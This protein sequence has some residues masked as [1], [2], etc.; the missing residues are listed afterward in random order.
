MAE[1]ERVRVQEAAWQSC[2]YVPECWEAYS[3]L[4]PISKKKSGSLAK[5]VRRQ[6]Q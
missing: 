6:V 3:A 2:S 1:K 5:R 4:F